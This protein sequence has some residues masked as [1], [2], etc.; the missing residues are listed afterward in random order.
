MDADDVCHADRFKTQI[1]F[2]ENNPDYVAVGGRVML[3]DPDGM[4][5]CPFIN[6]SKHEEIDMAHL[7][8]AIAH[9]SVVIRKCALQKIAG[10]RSE[11][12][13]AEDIDLF[14]RLAEIGKLANLPE[15]VLDYR[16]HHNSI[17]YKHA[18][19]QNDSAMK[20]I[21]SA[22]NRR[23]IAL[24]NLKLNNKNILNQQNITV[25][26]TYQKWAWWALSAGNV[27]TAKKYALM[28]FKKNPLNIHSLKLLL[29]TIR[30]Y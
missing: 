9:P 12:T 3:V 21:D 8:G 24:S 15:I 7:S 27:V 4:P 1:C 13:H 18:S 22:K 14:L 30:G 19:L 5:L 20:A 10:Y 6:L 26:N 23:G 17:G 28:S 11:F 16:Q 29:C 2:L 25:A